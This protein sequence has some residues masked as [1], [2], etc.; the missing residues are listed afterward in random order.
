VMGFLGLVTLGVG[1]AS[2]RHNAGAGLHAEAPAAGTESPET[3]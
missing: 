1:I 3:G 2:W